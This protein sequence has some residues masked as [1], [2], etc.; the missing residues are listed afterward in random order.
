MYRSGAMAKFPPNKWE[1]LPI[2]ELDR[3]IEAELA[4][5]A[6]ADL[7]AAAFMAC[8]PALLLINLS[9]ISSTLP[10]IKNLSIRI[11]I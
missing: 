6:Q 9:V 10:C 4:E 7:Q 3:L 1:C 8:K 5:P 2:E 11:E